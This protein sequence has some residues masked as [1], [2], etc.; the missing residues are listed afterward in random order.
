MRFPTLRRKALPSPECMHID[1]ALDRLGMRDFPLEWGTSPAWTKAP[2]Q[3]ER[4]RKCFYKYELVRAKGSFH[5]EKR[6]VGSGPNP[7]DLRQC[8]RIYRSVRKALSLGLTSGVVKAAKLFHSGRIEPLVESQR[9][10]WSAQMRAIFYTGYAH[11]RADG[12]LRRFR[13]LIDRRTFERWLER[14]PD[15]PSAEDTT[16]LP[17]GGKTPSAALLE[18]IAKA[19]AARGHEVDYVLPRDALG[20]LVRKVLAR[21]G[22]A[23]SDRQFKIALWTNID[24][25]DARKPGRRTR[26]NRA[27]FDAD[28][29]ALRRLVQQAL[30]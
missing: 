1:E 30:I 20:A 15:K 11:E 2:F 29:P 22:Y 5:L 17:G 9:G 21:E 8:D 13:V 4:E 14:S 25:S 18:R 3:Y 6:R 7:C 10:L 19:L 27:K 23:L 28:E 26:A 16:S 12:R 24:V